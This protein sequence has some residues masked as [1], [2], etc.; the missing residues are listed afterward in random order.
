MIRRI[1]ILILLFILSM[2]LERAHPLELCCIPLDRFPILRS[3]KELEDAQREII[4]RTEGKKS[5]FL[6][7]SAL[8]LL[9]AGRNFAPR[10]Y[11]GDDR[12]DLGDL[13]VMDPYLEA[14]LDATVLIIDDTIVTQD[15]K[16]KR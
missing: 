13:G 9:A 15:D 7:F 3:E 2:L 14:N 16:T 1:I 5:A 6:D 10:F 11:G 12:S 8:E 4:A